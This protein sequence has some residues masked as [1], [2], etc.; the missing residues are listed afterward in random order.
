MLVDVSV[1]VDD[2]VYSDSGVGVGGSEDVVM[3]E[4]LCIVR[5][6]GWISC[7]WRVI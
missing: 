1:E 2:W 6:L 5:V 3:D 4:R 7:C